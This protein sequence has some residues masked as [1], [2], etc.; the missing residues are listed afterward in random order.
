MNEALFQA[1]DGSYHTV[2]VF[3]VTDEYSPAIVI[4]GAS[5]DEDSYVISPAT[6]RKLAADL[7]QRADRF[8]G[9]TS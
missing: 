7:I 5:D 1:E 2:R 9:V 8:E 4:T 3:S 6:A